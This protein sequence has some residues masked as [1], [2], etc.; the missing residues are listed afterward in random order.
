VQNLEAKTVSMVSM[1]CQAHRLAS[2][3]YY[4]AADLC[5]TLYEITKAI[6]CFSVEIGLPDD[7]SE[8]EDRRSAVAAGMQAKWLLSETTV[9]ARSEILPKSLF[10]LRLQAAVRKK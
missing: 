10:I 6:F 8:Y 1:H 5:S 2:A 7:A 9:R 3:C 4:T